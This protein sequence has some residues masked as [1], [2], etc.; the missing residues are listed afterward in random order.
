MKTKNLFYTLFGIAFLIPVA[1]TLYYPVSK[2]FLKALFLVIYPK[3]NIVYYGFLIFFLFL[4]FKKKY[5]SFATTA[6]I[7]YIVFFYIYLG[8]ST[9]LIPKI[10]AENFTKTDK[11]A[12]LT[13]MD[14][15]KNIPSY[16]LLY[17]NSIFVVIQKTT[18]NHQA[19]FNYIKDRRR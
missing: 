13:T 8:L 5:S 15:L 19:P 3:M 9:Y 2:G 12:I 11:N 4:S 17:K 14:N 7:L 18:Y 6:G 16:K 1:I 10:K